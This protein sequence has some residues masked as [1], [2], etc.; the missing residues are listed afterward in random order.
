MQ[1]PTLD[2]DNFKFPIAVKHFDE[3]T[4]NRCKGHNIYLS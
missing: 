4:N 1:I 3:E 2:K